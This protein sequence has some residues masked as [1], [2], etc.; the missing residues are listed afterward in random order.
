MKNPFKKADSAKLPEQGRERTEIDY[1]HRTI[2][3]HMLYGYP[4]DFSSCAS[5]PEYDDPEMFAGVLEQAADAVK[6]LDRLKA[7]QLAIS[8]L[9]ETRYQHHA[10]AL[11]LQADL[12]LQVENLRASKKLIE[13]QLADVNARIQKLEA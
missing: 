9:V 7:Q 1:A 10:S 6:K 13:E 2:F 8:S 4:G 5:Y 11:N 3:H 12:R